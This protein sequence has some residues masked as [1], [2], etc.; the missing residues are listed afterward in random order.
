MDNDSIWKLEALFE[1]FFSSLSNLIYSLFSYDITLLC[2]RG[3]CNWLV[4]SNHYN[5]DSCWLT[6]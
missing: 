5:L 2:N 6:L 3:G 4:A 1:S